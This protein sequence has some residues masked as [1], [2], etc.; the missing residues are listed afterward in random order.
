MQR[1]AL[2][3]AAI[4]CLI[5]GISGS[6]AVGRDQIPWSD[7]L[8]IADQTMQI[9]VFGSALR[10]FTPATPENLAK[11]LRD[12]RF[13]ADQF[14]PPRLIFPDGTQEKEP[15]GAHTVVRVLTVRPERAVPVQPALEQMQS[16]EPEPGLNLQKTNEPESGVVN[17]TLPMAENSA[18]LV[19]YRLLF[20]RR[21][22]K[23]WDK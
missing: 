4:L 13:I 6:S 7:L 22:V 3:A 9:P 8:T 1:Q 17:Q 15:T 11:E 10:K 5:G 16:Q 19:D 12:D 23:E 18:R 21:P 14:P 20:N 2:T